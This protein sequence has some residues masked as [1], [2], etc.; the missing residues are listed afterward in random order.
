[1]NEEITWHFHST[2]FS[3]W[4]VQFLMFSNSE[5]TLETAVTRLKLLHYELAFFLNCLAIS[6]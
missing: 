6:R 2:Y 4:L 3:S 1:M 5:L